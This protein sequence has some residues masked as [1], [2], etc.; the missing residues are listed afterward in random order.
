MINLYYSAVTMEQLQKK[1][2][3]ISHDVS[4]SETPGYK[5]KSTNFSSLLVRELESLPGDEPG[6]RGRIAPL[7]LRVGSGARLG[8]TNVNMKQG[9]LKMTER[10]LDVAIL[11]EN[12]FFQV[13]VTENGVT[14]TRYTKAGNFYL[15]PVN[16]GQEAM[17]VTSE[18]Y[19]VTGQNGAILIPNDA[20]SLSINEDGTILVRDQGQTYEADRLELVEI[21]QPR[22][23]M[24]AGNN[25]FRFPPEEDLGVNPQELVNEVARE[26][27]SLKPG[28][29]E[30]SNVNMGE[31]L[32]ELLQTQRAYQF[33]ARAISI[34]DQMMG[35]IG[36]L[37]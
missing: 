6:N 12:Q 22:T 1:L 34:G 13:Q 10:P 33:N 21:D 28:A 2:D 11:S 30:V 18:G 9:A 16:G 35:L 19:P 24:A 7:D 17:L 8:H 32:T 36:N 3:M 14:E 27:A 5:D 15:Q 20:E 31:E 25:T 37:R 23:L 4:N 29:L 26:D